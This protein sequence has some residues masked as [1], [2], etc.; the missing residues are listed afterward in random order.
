MDKRKI[1]L[2]C[3]TMGY[4]LGPDGTIGR[5]ITQNVGMGDAFTSSDVKTAISNLQQL[6]ASAPAS[7]APQ[8]QQLLTAKGTSGSG[9]GFSVQ[10]TI[11]YYTKGSGS[12]P[13]DENYAVIAGAISA[14]QQIIAG[15][16]GVPTK[17]GVPTPQDILALGQQ[18]KTLLQSVPSGLTTQA[19]A[20]LAA[21]T[22]LS[23]VTDIINYYTAHPG[24]ASWPNNVSRDYFFLAQQLQALSALLS[25]PVAQTPSTPAPSGQVNTSGQPVYTP[26]PLPNPTVAAGTSPIYVG[27]TGIPS[28]TTGQVV[29]YQAPG[30]TPIMTTPVT[31]STDPITSALASVGLPA[32]VGGIPTSYL[33]IGGFLGFLLLRRRRSGD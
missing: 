27:P 22:G 14:A 9:G 19:N 12:G 18:F 28:I 24:P 8:L 21:K 3:P 26:P 17:I 16:G 2:G 10:D 15:T 25:A 32:S 20:I 13:A 29:P 31:V 11:N 4:L 30:Y 23:T 7:V 1:M 33:L 5:R 6:I